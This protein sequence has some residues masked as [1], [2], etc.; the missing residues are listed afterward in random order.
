MGFT[1]SS[2]YQEKFTKI[3]LAQSTVK[4]IEFEE[5]EFHDCSFVDCGFIRC[6]F[7][8]C[9][10][11]G[12]MIS[13]IVPTDCRFVDVYFTDS[14][15][16]GVDWTKAQHM[17]EVR[18]DRCQINYSN[19]RLLKLPK[20]TM[21]VCEAKEVDFTGTDLTEGDFT[22]TDFERSVFSKT[23]L[24]KANFTGAKN[25]FIDARQ[26]TIKKARFSLPEA[27]SLLYCLDVVIE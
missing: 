14:K 27:L 25:Y 4:E 17:R 12:C 15:V 18:F 5:C 16:I 6:R 21:T 9:T 26:N 23:I 7:I 20:M 24:T 10:F 3:S 22:Y 8:N 1:K 11:S 2:Y 19:F 13:A